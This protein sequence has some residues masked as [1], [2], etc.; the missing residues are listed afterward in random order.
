M[1]PASVDEYGFALVESLINPKSGL[2]RSRSCDVAT[3]V[4]VNALAV[5]AL[6]HEGRYEAA[7]RILRLFARHYETG[8]SDFHGFPHVWHPETGIPDPASIPWELEAA[9]VLMSLGYYRG[10]TG[11]GGSFRRLEDGLSSWLVHRTFAE[12]HLVAEASA[13]MYAA[14]GPFGALKPVAAAR[15]LLHAS[16]F[17]PGKISSLDYAH[18]LD[19]V[20]CGALACGDVSGFR[21]LDGFKRSA[22]SPRQDLPEF[23]GFSSIAGGNSPGIESTVQL[24]LAWTLLR[25]RV[26]CDL[27]FLD[28]Q[29]RSIA[30]SSPGS[31]GAVGLPRL[32]PW[33]GPE[34]GEDMQP[35]L[36]PT[37]MYL[38]AR[39]QL[40]PYAPGPPL[41]A[42]EY[43]TKEETASKS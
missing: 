31:P 43:R 25:E 32:L 23:N 8:E 30:V 10:A 36:E 38:F 37:C 2:A 42:P 21:F 16:L 20:T 19:H 5:I 41:H 12:E 9:F 33:Y 6:V 39:W 13:A 22:R 40:N 34:G 15:E 17:T 4:Y 28:R 26:P 14:L 27:S 3:T 24:F 18:V 7:E 35:A 1:A 29:L 11:N